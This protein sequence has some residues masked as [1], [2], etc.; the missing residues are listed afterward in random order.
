LK[1]FAR[2]FLAEI[3][4]NANFRAAIS[5]LAQTRQI[6]MRF[7]FSRLQIINSN[8]KK[9]KAIFIRIYKFQGWNFSSLRKRAELKKIGRDKYFPSKNLNVNAAIFNE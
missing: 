1:I 7:F 5:A 9:Q 8:E 2:L 4:P 6:P 3:D